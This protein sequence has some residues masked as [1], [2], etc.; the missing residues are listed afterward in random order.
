MFASQRSRYQVSANAYAL[1]RVA[2]YRPIWTTRTARTL[3][4][5]NRNNPATSH[6]SRLPR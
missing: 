5:I 1:L 3:S 4:P 6:A 2:K